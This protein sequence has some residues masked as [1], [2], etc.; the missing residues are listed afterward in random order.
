MSEM[1][2]NEFERALTR[3][4]RRVDAPETLTKFLMRVAEVETESRLPRRERKPRKERKHRW[5]WFVLRPQRTFGWTGGALA[6]VLLVSVFG[7]EQ[8]HVRHE[9]KQAEVQK[10]FDEGVRITDRA[11]DQTRE[12]LERAGLKLSN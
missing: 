4:M 7:V 8:V 3:A 10:Q 12:R 11:L 1:E 9:R 2:Q 5:A 6:A